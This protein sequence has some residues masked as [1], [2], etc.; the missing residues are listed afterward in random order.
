MTD[1]SF[2]ILQALMAAQSSRQA[3]VLATVVQAKGSV[4]RRAG[5]KMLVYEDGRT[6]GTI[7]GGEMENRVIQAARETLQTGSPRLISYALVDPQRGDPGVCGGQLE[8]YL[9]PFTT[10]MTVYV[11]GCGHIGRAVAS[12]AHWLGYRVV[13]TD[14]RTELV[15]P[16]HIP[17]ADVYLPGNIEEALSAEP[18][19]SN[20]YVVVVTRNIKVDRQVLPKLVNTPAPYIGVM[21]SKRRWETTRRLLLEDGLAEADLT[22]FHSPI[23]LELHAET[24]EEIALS[25]LAEIVRQ[26]RGQEVAVTAKA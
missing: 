11:I 24:P 7:G 6:L 23:G 16:E 10:P 3:V 20:T 9:E 26:R 13:V 4:P 25:I 1:S 8:I 18:I 15:T 5:A 12:L 2:Q 17:H 22:R 19:T 21:G 14:D